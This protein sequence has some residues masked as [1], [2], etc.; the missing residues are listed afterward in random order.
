MAKDASTGTS[1]R[2][3]EESEVERE[4]RVNYLPLKDVIC[5]FYILSPEEKQGILYLQWGPPGVRRFRGSAPRLPG[6]QVASSPP[7]GSEN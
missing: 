5:W 4:R 7:Q 2:T 1:E 6:R 3:T